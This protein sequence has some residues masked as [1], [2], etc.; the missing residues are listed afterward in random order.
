MAA[1]A[2]TLRET[3]DAP[4]PPAGRGQTHHRPGLG[5]ALAWRGRRA[6]ASRRAGRAGVVREDTPADLARR[7]VRL[8][9][10]PRLRVP[11]AGRRTAARVPGIPARARHLARL[12][13]H[14]GRSRRAVRG[15]RE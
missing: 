10:V 12:Y 11:A 15:P 2:H 1:P 13:R 8:E 9:A 14:H 5:A 7:L 4:P 3:A 6:R